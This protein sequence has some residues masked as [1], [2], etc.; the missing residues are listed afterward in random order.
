MQVDGSTTLRLPAGDYSLLS[1][2]DV[3]PTADTQGVALVGDPHFTLDGSGTSVAFDARTADPVTVD[4]GERGLETMVMRMDYLVDGFGGGMVAPV[5]VDQLYAQPQDAS[6]ADSF[7]FT[8]RWRLQHPNL[9]LKWGKQVL[10]TTTAPGATMLDR[11]V[12]GDAVAVGTGSAGTS[13]PST[14]AARSPWRSAPTR[15]RRP[16]RAANAAA[17]GAACWWS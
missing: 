4:V 12:K 8:N 6:D 3:A 17:A 5:W 10:D 14:C 11:E 7:S 2:M 16:Q 9:V 13:R 1:Y 15:S